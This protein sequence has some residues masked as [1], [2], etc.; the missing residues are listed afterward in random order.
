MTEN[1]INPRD[2]EH[3]GNMDGG[4]I[5]A[6]VVTTPMDD[7]RLS[8]TSSSSRPTEPMNE[9]AYSAFKKRDKWIIVLLVSVASFFSPLTANIYFPAIPT[10]ANAFHKST[11]L[12]N[13]T[14]TMYMVFQGIS[15]MVWGPLADLIGRRPLFL[16]CLFL[17]SASCVGLALVPTNAY[18]LLLVLRC[19]QAAG[20]ASTVALAAGCMGDI[21]TP[22]ERGSFFGFSGIGTLLGPA[23]GPVI[24]G[25]LAESLGWRSI[26]W[27][28]CIASA[29]AL[30][31]AYLLLPETLRAIV[32][33]GS[34]PP[35]RIYRTPI[36]LVRP[37]WTTPI[38]KRPPAKSLQNP[39]RL[40]MYPDVAVLLTFNGMFY[41]VFYGVTATISSIFAVRYPFLTETELGLVFLSVG[42][43]MVVG[44]MFTGK[45][46]DRDY[47]RIKAKMDANRGQDSEKQASKDDDDFPIE[48]ARL[49]SMPVY[50]S[51]YIVTVVGY[52]WSLRRDTHIAVPIILQFIR[53]L[54]NSSG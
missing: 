2:D 45:L 7:P 52:G 9:V 22:A 46:L 16:L 19:V 24:G 13:L 53:W 47:R 31:C 11:E 12:I 44:S 20:S 39:L 29:A 28:L 36:A 49:R 33:D 17:L 14:V 5:P 4:D 42:G 25:L 41:A 8:G 3:M 6:G 26:F 50:L 1:K 51:I 32:G 37:Q 54:S 43:G 15:P 35:P 38:E 30:V 40:L 10:I 23:I 27:F 21:A 18:W 34:I 48:L